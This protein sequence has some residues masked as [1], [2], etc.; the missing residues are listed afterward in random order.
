M[1]R[2]RLGE[3]KRALPMADL[4]LS[5]GSSAAASVIGKSV[6][7]QL[8]IASVATVIGVIG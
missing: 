4:L 5:F 2:S 7:S 6:S 8:K 3:R 1:T